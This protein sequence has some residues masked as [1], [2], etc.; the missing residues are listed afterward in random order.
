MFIVIAV[1]YI[2]GAVLFFKNDMA[3]CINPQRTK[4]A[5]GIIRK[6]ELITDTKQVQRLRVQIPS[7]LK[8]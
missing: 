5:R 8:A 4:A 1:I 3:K 7:H 2:A 6:K